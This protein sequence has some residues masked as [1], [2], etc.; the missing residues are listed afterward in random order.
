MSAAVMNSS[1]RMMNRGKRQKRKTTRRASFLPWTQNTNQNAGHQVQKKGRTSQ[2]ELALK[3]QDSCYQGD[4][5]ENI[6][7]ENSNKDQ[8]SSTNFASEQRKS[9]AMSVLR[10]L[11]QLE[12]RKSELQCKT[13]GQ[14]NKIVPL[15]SFAS[16]NSNVSTDMNI[17]SE[18]H[19]EEEILNSSQIASLEELFELVDA[20]NSKTIHLKDLIE[21]SVSHNMCDKKE[22]IMIDEY[23]QEVSGFDAECITFPQF[24]SIAIA[25]DL[26]EF[27]DLSTPA[28][29]I[30]EERQ[31][32]LEEVAPPGLVPTIGDTE[33]HKRPSLVDRLVQAVTFKNT[34]TSSKRHLSV[35]NHFNTNL[36]TSQ[37]KNDMN[38]IQK[39][40]YVFD[41]NDEK[42]LGWDVLILVLLVYTALWIPLRVGF[43]FD[44]SG[45]V[46]A[47]ELIVDVLFLTDV[48]VNF[49]TSYE[50]ENGHMEYRV[51]FIVLR[52]A[53]GWFAVDLISSIPFDFIASDAGSNI[54]GNQNSVS[55]L[56]STLKVLKLLRIFR[57]L[58]VFSRLEEEL[59]LQGRRP[60]KMIKICVGVLFIMH[61]FACG[62]ALM[63]R[64]GEDYHVDSW[65]A[66]ADLVNRKLLDEYFFSLYWAVTTLTTVGYGDISP[67]NNYE[68]V[69]ATF[70]MMVGGAL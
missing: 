29:N 36:M 46:K 67:V 44:P 51:S 25:F 28:S 19:T 35:L 6:N 3:R 14:N 27:N 59:N 30:L 5:N 50:C 2:L 49:L 15:S 58:R 33:G 57:A 42:R 13:D 62:W 68:V 39:P 17:F 34:K 21:F 66:Q 37:D 38:K 70:A 48:V 43:E 9:R 54:S 16:N 12:L 23:V 20:D 45:G 4:K 60:M 32:R 8:I 7:G 69:F 10:Q 31:K 40:I 55:T 65:V 61:L 11:N 1:R 22:A 52:Y 53:K 63:A 18:E 26:I 41:Q 24:S 64:Q 56:L 47:L